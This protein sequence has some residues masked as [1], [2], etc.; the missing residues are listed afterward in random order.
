MAIDQ[1]EH[2]EIVIDVV[3]LLPALVVMAVAMLV[4]GG[5]VAYYL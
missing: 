4:I 5:L 3:R 1:N 2:D